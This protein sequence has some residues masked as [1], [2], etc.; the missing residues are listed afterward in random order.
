MSRQE[1]LIERGYTLLGTAL[2]MRLPG[3][4]PVYKDV[5]LQA[6]RAALESVVDLA[7]EGGKVAPTAK[8]V[9]LVD[10]EGPRPAPSR[11]R[12]GRGQSK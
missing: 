2:S 4:S 12:T 8:E 7:L 5:I 10:H 11:K 6:A 1:E 3:L 9:V